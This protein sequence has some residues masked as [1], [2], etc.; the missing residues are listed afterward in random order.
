MISS[1]RFKLVWS[2]QSSCFYVREHS[3]SNRAFRALKSESYSR[4]LKYCVLLGGDPMPYNGLV[5]I[6]PRSNLFL[7]LLIPYI[8]YLHLYI[9]FAFSL[10]LMVA[11]VICVFY[12]HWGLQH[13]FE[14]SSSSSRSLLCRPT[15]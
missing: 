10:P 3:E 13:K 8:L 7:F 1:L 2:S 9:F 4:S 15:S 11:C 14:L 12:S 6:D 5:I